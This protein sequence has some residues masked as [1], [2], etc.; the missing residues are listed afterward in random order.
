M[1]MP[2]PAAAAIGAKCVDRCQL[3]ASACGNVSAELVIG[4]CA[5]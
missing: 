5:G 3:V 1:V 4:Q 2:P